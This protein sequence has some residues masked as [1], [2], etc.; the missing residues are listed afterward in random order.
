VQLR[1]TRAQGAALKMYG[2]R[3]KNVCPEFIPSLRLREDG[4]SERTNA[5]AALPGVAN[6]EDQLD[7]KVLCA[8]LQPLP[9]VRL[10]SGPA[11]ADTE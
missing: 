1:D 3:F 10:S 8:I 4:V 9:P 7:V 2:D 11:A 5:I 6:L